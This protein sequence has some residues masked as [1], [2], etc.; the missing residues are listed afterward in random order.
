MKTLFKYASGLFLTGMLSVLMVA[1]A[2]AQRGASHGGGGVRIGGGGGSFGG[3]FRGSN[4]GVA[5]PATGV[6]VRG[7]SGNFASLLHLQIS[8]APTRLIPPLKN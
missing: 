2:S 7:N 3:G 5:R 4:L 8:H 6:G 1:P